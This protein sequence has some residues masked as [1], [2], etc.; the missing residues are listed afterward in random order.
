MSA[1]R[2]ASEGV[3]TN[4]RQATSVARRVSSTIAIACAG[5][6][7]MVADSPRA[8]P[9]GTSAVSQDQGGLQAPAILSTT[10]V[11]EAAGVSGRNPLVVRF[12]GPMAVASLNRSITLVGPTGAEPVNVVPLAQG[13]LV[14]IWPAKELLPA[15]RYTLFINGATDNAQ[16]PL[17]LSAIG[18]DTAAKPADVDVAGDAASAPPGTAADP[19]LDASKPSSQGIDVD[20]QRSRLGPVE[21]EALLQAERS[22]D[23][24]DWLPGPQHLNG[25]W[26]A[27]RA[28]SPLQALPPLEARA[29][30]TAVAGQVLGMNGH[31]VPGVTLRI[32]EQEARTDV[33]GRF[34]LQGL[35]PGFAKLEIDGASAN[36]ADARYGYY[37][38]RIA[39]KPRQTN[40]V[41]YV[42]WMPRL[43]RAG[44]VHIAAPT[45][46]E[47][48]ITSPRIP[49]LELHI[50]AGTVIR[51]RQ[52]R[53]VTELNL[54]A[55][56]VDRPPFPVPDLGVP[57]YFTIQP[58]GAV[59]QS[60]TGKAGPGARLFY[61]NFKHEV[62]GARGVFWNY[63]PEDREWFVYGLGRIS[64]DGK[65]AIPDDGVVI[66]EFTG[67]MFDG[68]GGPPDPGPPPCAT[69][70]CC[71]P[72]GNGPGGGGCGNND[73]N[74]NSDA[75]SGPSGLGGDP[76]SL[77]TGQFEHTEHDMMLGDVMPINLTRTYDSA[78]KNQR[79][80]GVGMTHPYDVFLFSQNQYQEVDLIL[81]NGT[82]V[83]YVRTSPGTGYS[84]AIFQSS[85]PGQWN[86]SIVARNNTRFGWD[87]IFRDGR[88]WYFQQF[89]P[90]LEMTD[91]N[92]NVTRIVRQDNNGTGGKAMRIISPNGRTVDFNYNAAGF[93]SSLTDNLGRTWVYNYD[94]GGRLIEV[95]DPLGGTREY[96]WDTTNNR[97]TAIHDPNGNA[98]VLNEYD[99]AG[100]VKKQTLSDGSSFAF[101]YTVQNGLTTQTDV[102]DRRGSIRR[103]QFDA[104]GYVVRNTFPLGLPE[105]RSTTYEVANGQLT[106]SIDVL[107][108]RTEYQYDGA[109]N[110]TR[111]TRMAGTAHAITTTVAYDSVFNRPVAFTDANGN[112]STLAYDAKG[113]LTRISNA[114]GEVS[115][116]SYD[117]QGKRLTSTDPLGRV[118]TLS[119]DGADP[120]SMT[121]PLGRQRQY[122][123]DAVG[124]EIATVDP[125]GNRTISDWDDLNRLVSSTDA[126]GGVTSSTYDP[127]GNQ[128]SRV[129]AKGNTTSYT[130]N[131]LGKVQST[132]DASSRSETVVYEPGGRLKQVTDRK[133][134]IRSMTYDALGR[135]KTVSYGATAA[136]PTAYKSQ[137]EN[138]WDAA[139]RLTQIVDKTC[140]D[141]VNSP[142]CTTVVAANV[143]TRNYDDFDRMIAEVTPQG[144]VDYTYDNGGRKTTMTI[145]NG[146]PGAQVAQPT[147]TYTYDNANRLTGIHQ[148]AGD[149]NAGQAQAIA[150][151]YDAAGQ[152]TQITLANGCTVTYSYDNGGQVTAIV[153]K[154][155]DGTL[156]GDLH[157]E[158]DGNGRTT[159]VSGSLAQLNLPA[160]DV[161]DAM[162][163]AS[164]RL[165]TWSGSSYTYDDDG[166]L[167]GDGINTYQWDERDRLTNISA[168]GTAIASFQYDSRGRRTAKTIG[169]ETTGFLYD[170]RNI[171]QELT[172]TSNT[173][174]V[175]AHLLMGGMD[176]LFLRI[177]GNDGATRLSVLRDANNNTIML[178]DAAQQKVA[179]YTYEPYGATTT[180]ATSGNAQQYTGRENDAPGNE[181]GLYYY[182]ARYYMPG[183]ARF[184]S[185]DPIR[186]SNGQLNNYLYA[187]AS[188]LRYRDPLGLMPIPIGAGAGA[189][190]GI[191]SLIG[192][193]GCP[194]G[195]VVGAAVAGIAAVVAGIWAICHSDSDTDTDSNINSDTNTDI[196]DDGFNGRVKGC[197]AI[198]LADT[199]YCGETHTN[200]SVYNKCMDLAYQNYLRCLN[201]AKRMPLP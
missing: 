58:G 91:V 20:A 130:Y 87:L 192:P 95:V 74:S 173:S 83:H 21:Q 100:R 144:E 129:D 157:Y 165:L 201:G 25:R 170:G 48:V 172:G 161:T 63:D 132:L 36:R 124:R 195:A 24:E 72:G 168:G 55:I 80:F 146:A 177:E 112:T 115:T 147:I 4:G 149:I 194:A 152:R 140:G 121:D 126:L 35:E 85:A 56:P 69:G 23:P 160:A 99:N 188:P 43:D 154:K 77:F 166:N 185:E 101:A 171:V 31:A 78:D 142:S 131:S 104:L 26:H 127:D 106:A 84:D 123:T 16:R 64:R 32:G 5:A 68:P 97:I 138:T 158:Y 42:I 105:E 27:E 175:K 119:Y 70:A 122:L 15:S 198:Y 13:A 53:I 30:I 41:P 143:I 39:L 145:K 137:V 128:L 50:P 46:V 139:N 2:M 133:G 180:D 7:F 71:S 109:G 118:T 1:T 176:E 82:R 86:Q 49:G 178:L 108:R 193:E 12:T 52:G 190:C 54:T 181:Q 102:T 153:Y 66:H 57:V 148:A 28:P 90:L 62:P 162:Y 79:A 73:W 136:N 8:Q 155:A 47:T 182:R 98:V 199:A 67:A 107:N 17:L 179:D 191:G 113:N 10:P 19:A 14:Y 167:T 75:G 61:P 200:D 44:T 40:V 159:S 114:M 37:A 9:S 196:T 60:V 65:Q 76:V 184:I 18:F 186:W 3:L 96:T 33:T 141:P 150:L 88:K 51:D 11:A 110:T 189:G 22:S 29:G 116:F 163:D 38:A 34:L 135:V 94:A 169:S 120:T 92:G 6:V 164:N 81:P 111:I 134:M 103:V 151:V 174:V 197:Y 89:Q 187:D 59:L 117:D 125:V 93:V 45:P 183:N 156:L